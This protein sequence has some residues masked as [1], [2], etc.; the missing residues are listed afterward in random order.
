MWLLVAGIGSLIVVQTF[1]V[2]AETRPV[3]YGAIAVLAA[4]ASLVVLMVGFA[5]MALSLTRQARA[6]AEVEQGEG[7]VRDVL[8]HVRRF[9]QFFAITLLGTCFIGCGA[10]ATGTAGAIEQMIEQLGADDE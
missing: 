8:A 4:Y 10:I 6:V 2:D 3:G 1:V 7:A 5:M 9:W